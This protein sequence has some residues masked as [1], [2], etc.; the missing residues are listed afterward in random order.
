MSRPPLFGR[1]DPIIIRV[2][3]WEAATDW[4]ADKLGLRA[5]YTDPAQGFAVLPF[6]DHTLTIWQLKPDEVLPPR[7]TAV[8]YP[9]LE[10]S[11]A[12]ALQ[13]TLSARDVA[14][15][16]IEVVEGVRFFTF[17]DL[18]GNRLEACQ[19]GPTS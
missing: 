8:P 11:D 10:T 13:A 16:P 15:G 7:G 18:D 12:E 4:Y 2:R 19:L 1:I 14:V 3:N 17:W 6:N 9:I 5:T